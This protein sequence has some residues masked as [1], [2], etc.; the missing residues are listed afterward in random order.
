MTTIH[1]LDNA[2][3][4]LANRMARVQDLARQYDEMK[5]AARDYKALQAQLEEVREK[6]RDILA[7]QNEQRITSITQMYVRAD[8]S[9]IENN[10]IAGPVS[11]EITT[12][13]GGTYTK[14]LV[15]LEAHERQALSRNYWEQVPM[16]IR[17]MGDTPEAALYEYGCAKQRGYM[18]G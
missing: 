17:L 7:T 16:R 4:G 10:A 6:R 12:K 15:A 9:V 8:R 3:L 5:A 18:K 2:E 13:H 11:V 1:E 14:S